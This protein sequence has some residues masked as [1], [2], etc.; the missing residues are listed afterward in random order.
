MFEFRKPGFNVAAFLAN[1]GLVAPAVKDF[2]DMFGDND[3]TALANNLKTLNYHP[4]ANWQDGLDATLLA[5]TANEA[6][7]QQQ[8][9]AVEKGLFD[10]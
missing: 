5:I 7:V 10:L 4:A 6:V 9:V 3:P 2:V 1:A 8:K